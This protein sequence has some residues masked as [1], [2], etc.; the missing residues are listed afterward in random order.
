MSR[1]PPGPGTVST[2]KK[3]G[4]RR[5]SG[6]E[7]RERHRRAGGGVAAGGARDVI[8]KFRG[9]R[10]GGRSDGTRQVAPRNARLSR[11]LGSTLAVVALGQGSH[12]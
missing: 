12:D 11:L 9:V 5:E 6:I 3:M 7:E 2:L 8:G 10:E 1:G 4:G